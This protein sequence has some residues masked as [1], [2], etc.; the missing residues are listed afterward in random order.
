MSDGERGRE[1]RKRLRRGGATNLWQRFA[2]LIPMSCQIWSHFVFP[3]SRLLESLA[4]DVVSTSIDESLTVPLSRC[5]GEIEDRQ[6]QVATMEFGLSQVQVNC[7][8]GKGRQFWPE[9]LSACGMDGS[10]SDARLK[11]SG[12]VLALPIDKIS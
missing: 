4:R 3:K 5:G 11:L 12:A 7:L 1:A 8:A 2:A 10:T 6:L 9:L